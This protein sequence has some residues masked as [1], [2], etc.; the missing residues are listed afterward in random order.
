M[1]GVRGGGGIS[2]D[3][4]GFRDDE[5]HR[6]SVFGVYK[7]KKNTNRIPFLFFISFYIHVHL[8]QGRIFR[9]PAER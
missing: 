7:A 9:F 8:D 6:S 2:L 5:S 4:G 3:R 1:I